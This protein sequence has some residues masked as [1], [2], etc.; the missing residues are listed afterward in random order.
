MA[1]DWLAARMKRL[2]W[3]ERINGLELPN[4]RRN[5]IERLR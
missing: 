1:V 3:V 2:G 4:V 5:L